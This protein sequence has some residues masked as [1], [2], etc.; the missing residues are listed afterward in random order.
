VSDVNELVEYMKA[1]FGDV[2]VHEVHKGE[3]VG[4]YLDQRLVSILVSDWSQHHGPG[5]VKLVRRNTGID[6]LVFICDKYFVICNRGLH[7]QS[8][9]CRCFYGRV[10]LLVK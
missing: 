10:T 8:S 3:N 7:T 1:K 2:A 5:R 4:W 6:R 9:G